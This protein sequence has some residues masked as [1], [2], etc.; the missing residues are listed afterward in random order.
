MTENISFNFGAIRDTV[1]KLSASEL[2]RE[3]K[4]K[5]LDI[6]LEEIKKSPAL[7]KQH[8]VF[9]NIETAKPFEKERLAERFILQNLQLFKNER[10]E[11]IVSENKRIRRELLD[12]IHIESRLDNK[13]AESINTLIEFHSTIGYTNFEKEQEAFEYVLGHLTRTVNES[14]K[15]K[16]TTDNPNILNKG[17]KFITQ[18]AVSNFNERYQHL[19]EE[20][21]NV[22][23]ILISDQKNKIS[24]LEE[25]K[26]RNLDSIQKLLET[27]KDID[28]DTTALLEKFKIKIENMKGANFV[29][30]D[31]YILANLEL[32]TLIK[33]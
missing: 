9:K 7:T 25:I 15:S 4:S 29:N 20:E 27:N 6:F 12:D 31:E 28:K 22:F 5:T 17:W 13:L 2:I 33:E 1:T 24:Y 23:S 16:E 19:N 32:E 14:D 11:N 26:N 8:F 18:A 10:W 21:K 3:Q 30:L